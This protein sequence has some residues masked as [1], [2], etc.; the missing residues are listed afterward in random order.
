MRGGEQQDQTRQ[1]QKRNTGTEKHQGIPSSSHPLEPFGEGGWRKMACQAFSADSFTPLTL[2]SPLPILMHHAT[3]T[4]CLP[5]TSHA[6]SMVSPGK[7]AL[8]CPVSC[9][10][11]QTFC[12]IPHWSVA[13][14][15]FQICTKLKQYFPNVAQAK[16]H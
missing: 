14:F 1:P 15:P 9:S 10:F 3:T 6:H 13:V 4:D 5:T 8:N 11:K 7:P 2:D 12:V 16:L